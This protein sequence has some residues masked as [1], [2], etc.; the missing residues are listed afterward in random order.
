MERCW[1]RVWPSKTI[2]GYEKC[3]TQLQADKPLTILSIF[4]PY[5]KLT[6]FV[7]G[8]QSLLCFCCKKRTW[9]LGK[10]M[11]CN[12]KVKYFNCKPVQTPYVY[13]QAQPQTKTPSVCACHNHNITCLMLKCSAITW[14]IKSTSIRLLIS[15]FPVIRPNKETCLL[16]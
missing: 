12:V 1:V 6:I 13:I 15:T 7:N 14:G 4:L 2:H 10:Q 9:H 11:I 16:M 8:P 3:N 5:R